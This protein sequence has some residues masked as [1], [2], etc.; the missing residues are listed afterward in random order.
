[1]VQV[2]Q[3][4]RRWSWFQVAWAGLHFMALLMHVLS[5]LYHLR[6]IVST[7][8]TAPLFTAGCPAPHAP[9]LVS[10]PD[11]RQ[12]TPSRHLESCTA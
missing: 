10:L 1:L 8:E 5:V 3:P 4:T 9:P 6:R 7:E 12:D 2:G 11:R